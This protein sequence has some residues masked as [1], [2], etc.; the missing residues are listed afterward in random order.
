[1]N[2]NKKV[3][4]AMKDNRKKN[5]GLPITAVVSSNA[6][7][8][9]I[10]ESNKPKGKTPFKEFHCKH[11]EWLCMDKLEE[12]NDNGEGKYLYI[13][14]SPCD[15]CAKRIEKFSFSK[16]FYLFNKH[17]S[18]KDL[19]YTKVPVITLYKH[20]SK[21][22]AKDIKIMKDHLTQANLTNKQKTIR[23]NNLV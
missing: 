12:N 17:N 6:N 10:I 18:S 5:N 4:K 3:I 1:M 13:T 14:T 19:Y 23:K 8:L 7:P 16:V 20:N 22:Q 21:E 11:A 2:V 9:E 15:Y